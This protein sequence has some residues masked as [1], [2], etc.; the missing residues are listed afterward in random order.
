MIKLIQ[1]TII[2]RGKMYFGGLMQEIPE[3]LAEAIDG[4]PPENLKIPPPPDDEE[5]KAAQEEAARKEKEAAAIRKKTP[6]TTTEL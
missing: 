2:W 3:D 4:T 6:A 5:F 1:E